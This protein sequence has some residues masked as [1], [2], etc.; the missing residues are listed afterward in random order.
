MFTNI[1]LVSVLLSVFV[2]CVV[3]ERTCADAFLVPLD[4]SNKFVPKPAE[5]GYKVDRYNVGG[6]VV[7]EIS[8][9]EASVKGFSSAEFILRKGDKTAVE[10]IVGLV[11]I[12]GGKKGL[13]KLIIDPKLIDGGNLDIWSA[14]IDGQPPI[15]NFGGFRFDIGRLMSPPEAAEKK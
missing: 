2:L 10:S 14:P 11:R 4:G 1:K 7:I 3:A 5:F 13:L 8:L 12:D 15:R 6:Q 9:N